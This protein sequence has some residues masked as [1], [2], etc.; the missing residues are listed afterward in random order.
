VAAVG[1]IRGGDSAC[2][3]RTSELVS[4]IMDRKL[5]KESRAF[6]RTRRTASRVLNTGAIFAFLDRNDQW[7]EGCVDAYHH[8][9]LP[10]PP[11]GALLTEALHL[12]RRNLHDDRAVWM[13]LPS[14]AI[15]MFVTR[16]CPKFKLSC[17]NAP[18]PIDLADATLVH[19]A[20]REHLNVILTIDHHDFE[21]YR[22]PGPKRVY[23]PSTLAAT[24]AAGSRL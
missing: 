5:A 7:H 11:T 17:P 10:W 22:L 9:R 8:N 23:C 24:A 6:A 15:R 12:V 4:E 21:T 1:S 3:A 14:G 13:L 20:A 16:N 19:L 2:S 18:T